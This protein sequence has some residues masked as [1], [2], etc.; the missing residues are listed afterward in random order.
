MNA[1]PHLLLGLAV[2]A[3]AAGLF[4]PGIEFSVPAVAIAALGAL[5]PDVDHRK[6]KLFKAVLLAIFGC[7]AAIA[8]QIA[9]Q[10]YNAVEST[11]MALG[12]GLASVALAFL[13]K[14]RHRG[15]THSLAALA[16]FAL[17][18][19]LAMGWEGALLGGSAYASHLLS[20]N[21][22]KPF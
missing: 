4:A 9:R 3:V 16:L 15:F 2:A 20:D 12:A 7:V 11:A 14:P 22:I 1:L 18:A 13:L 10:H 5:A 17:G 21:V 8:F 6:T 19:Y